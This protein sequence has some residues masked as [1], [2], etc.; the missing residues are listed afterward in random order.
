MQPG[1]TLSET[2]FTAKIVE[3][4]GGTYS[5]RARKAQFQT[6][7][8]TVVVRRKRRFPSRFDLTMLATEESQAAEASVQAAPA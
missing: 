6:I 2:F 5:Y 7:E 3:I 8:G 4:S 1:E